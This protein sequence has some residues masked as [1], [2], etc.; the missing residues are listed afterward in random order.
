MRVLRYLIGLVLCSYGGLAAAEPRPYIV[1]VQTSSIER[2]YSSDLL[3]LVLNASK[4]PDE[5]IQI[6]FANEYLSQARWLAAVAQ[7]S[8]NNVIWTM[9]S[10]TREA[11]L[12]PI[13]FPMTKGLIGYRALVVRRGDEARFATV[14]SQQDLL[15]LKVGQGTHWPDT[16]ILRENGFQ[17]V[18][19]VALKNLYKMLAAKRFDF[20]PRGVTEVL[21]ER[22]LIRDSGLAVEP[23]LILHYPTDMYFFVNKKNDELAT[24]I[25]K[26]WVKILK[27]GEFEK[28]FLSI[29]RMGAAVEFLNKNK[30]KMI[31]LENPFLSDETRTASQP[32]WLNVGAK[33]GS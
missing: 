3:E 30:Y 13:R 31:E 33:P 12:R 15:A 2:G 28:F 27:N 10:K 26:G 22:N 1:D 17:I 9:T 7:G 25:E 24:R 32:Y 20:F 23:S 18:E 8:G 16:D 6:R 4:A 5:V 11:T 19:A 14:K 21:L 29:G